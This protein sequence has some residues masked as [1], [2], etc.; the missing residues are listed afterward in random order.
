MQYMDFR[1][2]VLVVLAVIG[3][4]VCIYINAAAGII[5][6]VA[7]ATLLTLKLFSASSS[8]PVASVVPPDPHF[9]TTCKDSAGI[10]DATITDVL[11]NM[12]MVASIQ[13]DAIRTLNSAFSEFKILLDT[14]QNDVHQILFEG[15][16]SVRTSTLAADTSSILG[17]LIDTATQMSEGSQALLGKVDKVSAEMPDVMK[18]MKDIDQIASQTNLLALNA[19]IEAARAGDAGRGFAVVADEVRA[20]SNR[21]AGFSR[22]IQ[23]Q[24]TGINTAV[25]ALA[26]NA[27][28]VASQ[29]MTCVMSA[30]QD[31]EKTV[32]SLIGKAEADLAVAAGLKTV[33]NQLMQALHDAMRGLQFEDISSQNI[34]YTRESLNRL[35]PLVKTLST[36]NEEGKPD[37]REIIVQV[38]KWQRQNEARKN[39]PVSA[40]SMSSGE[41][42]FF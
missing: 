41:V 16:G 33:S 34:G 36:I 29:D 3:W 26:D 21:S 4:L 31:V 39:N 37:H 24:L 25:Q 6:S 40:N 35:W 5:L 1:F 9:I 27:R 22:H 10:I 2:A 13:A 19:A 20:L 23:E 7:G 30:R 18:A 28:A 12:D 8:K 17:R 11:H 14:Q 38:E 15:E 32:S 42:D